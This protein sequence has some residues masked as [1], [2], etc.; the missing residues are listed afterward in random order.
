MFKITMLV[1]KKAELSQQ[2]FLAHWASHSAKVLR[3][4]NVLHIR[5]Y[6]K[7]LPL[8]AASQQATQRHTQAFRFD[9]MGE[10]WY[11]SREDFAAARTTPEGAAALAELRADEVRFVDMAQSVMWLGEEECVVGLA[12]ETN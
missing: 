3:Y 5:R 1:K 7:T 9:A 12:G 2:E 8:D 4:H 6:A 11:D 10:L